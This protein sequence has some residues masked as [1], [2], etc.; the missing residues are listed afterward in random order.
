[1][2]LSHTAGFSY[3]W[4][5]ADLYKWCKKQDLGYSDEIHLTPLVNEPGTKWD[6]GMSMDWAGAVLETASGKSLGVWA[7]GWSRAS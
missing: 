2:L 3:S 4:Y 6:Y 1:M 5:N 7:K